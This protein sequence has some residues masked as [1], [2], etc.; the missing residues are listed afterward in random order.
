MRQLLACLLLLPTLVGCDEDKRVA[1]IARESANRQAEQNKEMS[2]LNR[3][4]AEGAKLL[5]EAHEDLTTMEQGIHEQQ[6]QLEFDRKALA[7]QRR[8]ESILGPAIVTTG[9]L[10]ACVLPLVVCW[11]LLVGMSREGNDQR[12]GEILLAEFTAEQPL[13]L[14]GDSPAAPA[15]NLVAPTEVDQR[16]LPGDTSEAPF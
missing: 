9:T 15:G 12:L 14:P 7:A 6:N 4:V 1:E 16:L 5:A 2:Q 8:T 11:Y 3:E 10:L 13:L